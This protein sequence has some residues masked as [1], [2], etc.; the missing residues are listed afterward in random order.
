MR[1]KPLMI[2]PLLHVRKVK[3]S[4]LSYLDLRFPAD[5]WRAIR[6]RLAAWHAACARRRATCRS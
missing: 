6:P 1:L 4:S 5:D 2:G 3:G